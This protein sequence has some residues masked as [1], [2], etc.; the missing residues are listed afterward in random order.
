MW[1]A[2]VTCLFFWPFL[3]SFTG[4]FCIH[5][6]ILHTY[7]TGTGDPTS[8]MYD[9]QNLKQVFTEVNG[10]PRYSKEWTGKS[11]NLEIHMC[12]D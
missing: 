4:L 11:S 3:Y 12:S 9:C 1:C 2:G 7:T 5:I 6:R 10:S 8:N